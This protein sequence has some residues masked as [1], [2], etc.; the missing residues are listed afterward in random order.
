MDYLNELVYQIELH[1]VEGMRDSFQHGV[2][3]NDHFKGEP[4]IAELTSEY[5]R[6]PRFKDCVKLFVEFGLTMD[7]QF[8]L[9]VLLD[10]A[11]ALDRLLQEQPVAARQTVSLRCAYT[12]L[13][14]ASLLHV[15]AEF[16]HVSCAQVLLN[17]GADINAAAGKDEHGFGGQTPIFHTVNQNSNNSKEMMSFLLD[18]NADLHVTVPGITWG[19]SYEWETLI[20]AVNP[21]SYAMMGMLPQM[22]RDERTISSTVLCLLKKA[23][24]ISYDAVNVPCAYLH[25]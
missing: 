16:N 1:D 10:D 15:C 8:L 7:N 20:P 24:G 6:T 17:F 19:K 21:V 4:L 3:P 18:N 22:H 2:H 11:P 23:Y 13:F 9:S 5:T 12:P 14:N 25:R